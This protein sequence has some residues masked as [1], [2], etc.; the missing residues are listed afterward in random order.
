[1]ERIENIVCIKLSTRLTSALGYCNLRVK[2]QYSP[3]GV[4]N[5][6]IERCTISIQKNVCLDTEYQADLYSILMHEYIHALTPNASHGKKWKK[7]AVAVNYCFPNKYHITTYYN[8]DDHIYKGA[9]Y[10]LADAKYV[11]GCPVCGWKKACQRLSGRVEHPENYRCKKCK[12]SI[13][14]YK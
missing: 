10:N 9:A 6:T 1:M 5:Y 7:F 12:S 4:T 14:R 11:I 8:G 3:N 13:V 2:E